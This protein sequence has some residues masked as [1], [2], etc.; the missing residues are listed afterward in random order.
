M[1]LN[2]NLMRATGVSKA[3]QWPQGLSRR[4]QRVSGAI[5]VVTEE[6]QGSQDTWGC[7]GLSQESQEV[8][9]LPPGPGFKKVSGAFSGP[10]GNFLEY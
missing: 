10:Q 5:Q 6:F 3:F 2:L 4:F 1:H 9:G 7:Q 8:T